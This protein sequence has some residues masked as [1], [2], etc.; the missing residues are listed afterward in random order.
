VAG[1]DPQSEANGR[2]SRPI[3][4]LIYLVA[5][6]TLSTLR[7]QRN[8]HFGGAS[9][10]RLTAG[11]AYLP[12]QYRALIPWIAGALTAL[13]LPLELR[14]VYMLLEAGAIMALLLA[15]RWLLSL[16]LR[17][18][19]RGRAWGLALLILYP[20]VVHYLF[21][22]AY[23]VVYYP[24]DMPS[25][26][27]FAAG[28]ALLHQGRF[29]LYYPLFGLATLNRETSCFLTV[30]H[31]C[32]ADRAGPAGRRLLMHLSAQVIIWASIK[33]G[34]WL[35]YSGNTMNHL[36]VGG[37]FENN[38]ALNLNRLADPKAWLALATCFGLLWFPTLLRLGR[39]RDAFARRALLMLPPLFLGMAVTGNV[40]ELRIY[41]EGIPALTAAFIAAFFDGE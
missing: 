38:I 9:L 1:K 31:L 15:F 22:L 36:G 30:A 29:R 10:K 34:L 3:L 32:T 17:P 13:G 37:L 5:A 4:V 8:M 28:L 25:L 41:G 40:T 20:L 19:R 23:P 18:E 14:G 16:L 27:F 6:A 12:Y 11:T 21:W 24:Y 2:I 26:A 7:M 35:L 33:A 39:I